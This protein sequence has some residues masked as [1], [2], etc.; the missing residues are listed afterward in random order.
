MKWFDRMT[1]WKKL[2][3]A[4]A[5]VIAFGA[6]VGATGLMT[7]SSMHGITEAICD[8]DMDGLYWMEEANRN[9]IDTDLAAANLGYAADDAGRQRLKQD[10]LASL[11]TMHDAFDHYR[12]TVTDDQGRELLDQVLKKSAAWEAI[13]H[14]Q[15]GIE[16]VPVGVDN[17]ELVRRAIAA[18]VAMRE[19][20]VA[21]L[22][23]R[24][25][26]AKDAQSEATAGYVR[27]RIVMS[28][29]V[30]AS[31]LA[32]ALLAWL[33]ARRLT[34][35]LGGE[36][37]YAAD[38]A[39]RIAGGDLAVR[40]HTR[41]GDQTSLLFALGNMREQLAG[42]VGGISESSE[43]ILLA[44]SEIAQGNADLSQR[45]E[46][47]AASLEETASSMEQLT[48]TVRQ[49]ADNAQQA[50]GVAHGASEVAARGSGLVDDV[51]AT[52]R[53]LATGSKRMTD[54][55]A[56]IESIAF[57]TNILALNAAVEAARAGEQGRGFAVVA[58]EVRSLA[59]R[60]AVSAKEIKELIEGST[61]R[62]DSGATLAERAGAT[63][64]EVTQ[65]VRRVTD[66]MGEISAASNEQS[67]G[68]DQVNRAV[69]QM[70]EVTQQNAALV[71]QAAAAAGSMADQARQLKAA[72]AVFSLAARER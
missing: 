21:A 52:M 35:Q 27:M 48:A 1:V 56:V 25:K 70:D 10:I 29:L 51:V 49:N 54:I 59:Q 22:D 72:V 24:R 63:M 66:I 4:F 17:A 58:G 19:R 11:A 32:G 6:V 45:T 15:I 53:E 20:I 23:A 2:M 16:P 39:N 7:L 46:E 60:S 42:I 62:V 40:V 71:E 13:V 9:K 64:A 47:Q 44:S 36:P 8:R 68:I 28:V 57:Q 33:I 43:S 31:I 5:I 65:A 18:S 67:T 26:E 30:L 37:D 3:L 55:I 69:A 34:R 38:I 41:A 50:S 12:L 61:A 14:Q